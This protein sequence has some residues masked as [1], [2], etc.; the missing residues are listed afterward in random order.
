M[1]TNVTSLNRLKKRDNFK[2]TLKYDIM[3]KKMLMVSTL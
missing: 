3:S 2:L 1:S